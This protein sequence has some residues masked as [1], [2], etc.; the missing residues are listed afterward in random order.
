MLRETKLKTDVVIVGGGA[1]GCGIARDLALRGIDAL[2]IEQKDVAYGATGRCHGLLHSGVRYAVSDPHAARECILENQIIGRVAP[3][4]VEPVGGMVIELPGDDPSYFLKLLEACRSAGIKTIQITPGEAK[5]LEPAINPKVTR[6]FLVPD[7]S[8]DPFLLCLQNLRAA[9]RHGGRYLLHTKVTGFTISSGKVIGVKFESDD[10]HGEVQCKL[11]ILAAGGWSKQMAALAGVNIPMELSKGSL[12]IMN[13]RFTDRV[14]NRS[15]LPSDGDLLIPNGPTSIIGTTSIPVPSADGL[16][17]ETSEIELL[18]RQGDVMT[19]GFEKARSLRAYAGVRPLLAI[20]GQGRE[21]TRG[22][23]VIDHEK[24]DG[25]SGLISILGGK[26]T[27][28]RLMAEKTADLAAEKLGSNVKCQTAERPLFEDAILPHYHRSERLSRIHEV[29]GGLVCECEMVGRKHIL[30]VAH[31]LKGRPDLVDI[32]HRTRL[33]M[34]S[35]QGGFCAFRALM[36]LVEEGICPPDKVESVLLSFLNLRW[37]GIMPILRDD[38]ARE[39]H[40]NYAIYASLFDLDR[41][42]HQKEDP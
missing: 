35:C 2:L 31:E 30:E 32:Q 14:I 37:K 42:A 24:T 9:E 36:I 41:A 34:G 20:G 3:E 23:L 19:P 18:M 28:Y 27:T 13:R 25:I 12:I 10:E 8:I 33:G 4:C 21:A 29:E 6:S 15:R 40:L 5:A 26:L 17:I 1:T 11:V 22:F 38:M 7:S 16:L 39:E